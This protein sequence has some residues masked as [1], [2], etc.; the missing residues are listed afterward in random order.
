[1]PVHRKLLAYT[2]REQCHIS[3][4]EICGDSAVR[5]AVMCILQFS[6]ICLVI[7]V[8]ASSKTQKL[9][10][11]VFVQVMRCKSDLSISDILH[12][13]VAAA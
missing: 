12:N 2:H 11:Q 4:A 7:L 8:Q 5:Q 13:R 6:M 9:C 10:A 1:M 3:S